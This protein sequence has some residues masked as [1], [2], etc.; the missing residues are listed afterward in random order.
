VPP[1]RGKI[2]TRL[3]NPDGS[4]TTSNTCDLGEMT[5][6][7]LSAD[8]LARL[9]RFV[10]LMRALDWSPDDLDTAIAQLQ[11]GTPA[12]EGRLDALL[13]RQLRAV[14]AVVRRFDIGVSEAV[15]LLG[16]IDTHLGR[17]LPGDDARRYCLYNRLFQNPVV[18]NPVD[19][20]YALNGA[21]AE[22][23]RPRQCAASA[24]PPRRWATGPG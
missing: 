10:R 17:T 5:V 21:R 9:H 20:G 19:P 8:L 24:S 15:A 7:N 13:L 3:V 11:A 14:T 6:A 18:V 12:G 23:A 1:D 16:G 4:V 22:V 2:A